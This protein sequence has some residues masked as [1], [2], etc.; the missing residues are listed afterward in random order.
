MLEGSAR[1][2]AHSSTSVALIVADVR[3]CEH[4]QRSRATH[5][6]DMLES[7]VG[8]LEEG[9][10]FSLLASAAARHALVNFA[11]VRTL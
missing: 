11:R 6:F 1:E 5:M 8:L 3:P 7:G 2:N 10:A 4:T 9:R